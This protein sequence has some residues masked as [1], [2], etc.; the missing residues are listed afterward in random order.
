M[1][2]SSAEYVRK[3]TPS[4]FAFSAIPVSFVQGAG[5]NNMHTAK[6]KGIHGSNVVV[7]GSQGSRL[8]LSATRR[9]TWKFITDSGIFWTRAQKKARDVS[10]MNGRRALNGLESTAVMALNS[11]L[12]ITLGLGT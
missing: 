7:L 3:T 9:W 4:G 12:R 10:Y 11:V 2:Q 5:I 6:L 1:G 8:R